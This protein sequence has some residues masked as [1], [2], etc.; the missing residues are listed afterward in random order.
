MLASRLKLF[1]HLCGASVWVV[2]AE[3]EENQLAV[4]ELPVVTTVYLFSY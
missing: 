4:F 3:R 1:F 2:E